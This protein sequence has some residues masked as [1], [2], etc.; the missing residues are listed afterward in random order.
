MKAKLPCGLIEDLL[1][2]YVEG[3]ASLE[4]REAVEEHLLGCE[5]CREAVKRL[6]VREQYG[7]ETL[8]PLKKVRDAIRKK[9]QKTVILAVLLVLAA[10]VPVFSWL[11]RAFYLPYEPGLVQIEEREDQLCL[12]LTGECGGY[13]LEVHSDPDNDGSQIYTLSMWNSILD[14]KRVQQVP[15]YYLQ[16]AGS[17]SPVVFYCDYQGEDHLIYGEY[18]GGK[19]TLK[20]LILNYYFLG[21]A[22]LSMAFGLALCFFWKKKKIR[23]KLFNAVFLPLSYLAAHIFIM[24]FSGGASADA[25]RD[26]LL[27]LLTSLLLYGAFLC[28]RSI[29]KDREQ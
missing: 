3:I 19:R 15:V 12:Y 25:F 8:L 13:S 5:S 26:F 9:R 11:T 7:K 14:K 16:G 1:P 17:K 23:Q 18:D 28:F 27:I 24:G 20:R 10:V 29:Q 6:T 4:S 21:A 2:L 22:G